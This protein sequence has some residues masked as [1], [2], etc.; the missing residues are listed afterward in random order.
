MPASG[1]VSPEPARLPPL[2]RALA[3]VLVAGWLGATLAV[4]WAATGTFEVLS[5]RKNAALA[6]KFEPIPEPRRGKLLR[7]AAGEVNRRLFRGWNQ[8]QLLLGALT[9]VL[10][11]WGRRAGPA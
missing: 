8:G 5:A 7:H 9:L 4:W 1:S 6:E 2:A 11:S 10:L 3:L